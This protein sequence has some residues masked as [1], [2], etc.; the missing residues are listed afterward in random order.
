MSSWKRRINPN[1]PRN[2]SRINFCIRNDRCLLF[3]RTTFRLLPTRVLPQ[4]LAAHRRRKP[5][6]ILRYRSISLQMLSKWLTTL[7]TI[8]AM[9][10]WTSE[11]SIRLRMP[12]CTTILRIIRWLVIQMKVGRHRTRPRWPTRSHPHRQPKS[13]NTDQPIASKIQG[14]M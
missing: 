8:Q 7:P 14:I 12:R 4:I 3:N 11:V 13:R 2:C 6:R 1:R 5:P 9:R 10:T